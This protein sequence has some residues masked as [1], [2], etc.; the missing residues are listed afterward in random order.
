MFSAFAGGSPL[1]CSKCGTSLRA[2]DRPREGS[3]AAGAPR[4]QDNLL[5]SRLRAPVREHVFARLSIVCLDT[6]TVLFE[7]GAPRRYVYFPT[8][9]IMSLV[10]VADGGASAEISVVGN[11]GVLGIAA[12]LGGSSSPSRAVVHYAGHAFRMS[13]ANALQ[14]FEHSTQMQHLMLRYLHTLMVQMAQTA[15]CNRHHS[16]EQQLCRWLLLSL[17]RLPTTCLHMTQ[18]LIANM[19]GVRREGVNHAAR[20]LQRLGV[21]SCHRG[22]ITVLDR[23]DLERLS[24]SCYAAVRNETAR[25][26]A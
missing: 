1:G 6:D 10:Y 13:A 15:V 19:L 8:D 14:A 2:D 25:L 23:P 18:E 11:D 22:Q 9:A 4:P 16:I 24:C 20:K 26:L 5:L 12:L 7:P 17:D 21:I 3:L